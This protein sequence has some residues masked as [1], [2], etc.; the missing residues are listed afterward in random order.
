[1]RLPASWAEILYERAE[2]EKDPPCRH[3]P[4]RTRNQL[5]DLPGARE[6]RREVQCRDR[7]TVSPEQEKV[8]AEM[9]GQ[10]NI[11]QG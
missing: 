5:D 1:M 8:W 10:W 11:R 7:R 2:S 3:E 4:K 6:K 9:E